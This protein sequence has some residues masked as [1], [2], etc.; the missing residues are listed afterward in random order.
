[1][2]NDDL[3]AYLQ[4]S[5]THMN[6]QEWRDVCRRITDIRADDHCL[7]LRAM[8]PKGM[9]R[10]RIETKPGAF[11]MQLAYVPM[12]QVP[13]GKQ[14]MVGPMDLDHFNQ[15]MALPMAR[16]YVNGRLKGGLWFAPPGPEQIAE[17][18]LWADLGFEVDE[19]G[20]TELRL[21][22]VEN[23]Q[24]SIRWA[25]MRSIEVR[26]DD[27][28]I[29]ELKP[30]SVQHPRVLVNVDDRDMLRQRLEKHPDYAKALSQA[31]FGS[32]SSESM[33]PT[34]VLY[35]VTG[36]AALGEQIRQ[37]AVELCQLPTWSG[38]PDPLLMGGDN[39]RLIGDRLYNLGMAWEYLQDLF[40]A[41]EKK[42]VLAKAEEY[43]QKMYDFTVLQRGY[44][45][46]PTTDAHSLGAWFGVATA[47]MC[48]YDDL[49]I[50]RKALAFFH[51]LYIESLRLFPPG[52][53]ANW[54]TFYP[55][56]LVR[57]L[58]AAH[59]FG[60]QRPELDKSEFLD[61]LGEALFTCYTTPNTQEMQS[62]A[63]TAPHRFLVAFL[64]RFHPTPGI[65]SIYRSFAEYEEK[66][67]GA[68]H[69]SLYDWLYAPDNITEAARP[70]PSHPL[71]IRDIGEV[72]CRTHGEKSVHASFIAGC[73]AGNRASFRLFPHNRDN[74]VPLGTFEV[75]VDGAPVVV[76]FGGYGRSITSQNTMCF[77]DG[78]LLVE[79]QYINGDI[80]AEIYASIR[81]C[82]ISDRFVYVHAVLTTGL[83]PKLNIRSAERIYLVDYQTGSIVVKDI[84]AGETPLRFA[85]HLHCSGSITQRPDGEY[86]LTGGQA[87]TIACGAATLSDDE[88]GEAF[89]SILQADRPHRVVV[90]EPAWVPAY[91]YNIN[92][93]GK[94]DFKDSRHPHYQRWRLEATELV[95]SGAFLFTVN[96]TP[97]SVSLVKENVVALPQDATYYLADNATV[98]ALGCSI[99]A[100]A[101]IVDEQAH[102]LAILGA[103]QVTGDNF[104]LTSAIPVDI[105]LDLSGTVARGAIFATG[106]TALTQTSGLQL[107]E[108]VFNESDMRS[109]SPWSAAFTVVAAVGVK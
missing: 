64:C 7:V 62:G 50:A 87:K 108:W 100:E 53:K 69:M 8:L 65:E 59:T 36:D 72:V 57:Y 42:L 46:C 68:V 92:F 91:V 99:V 12:I 74:D 27:R 79:G 26:T 32:R 30:A 107:A 88:R 6:P 86:R 2:L 52:G 25:D 49:P 10:A 29:Y 77:N 98:N 33:A 102:T 83:D 9:Y 51:G 31:V 58:A 41:D 44:M 11:D 96:P 17:N 66:T 84:F 109:A 22:F 81:R 23:H 37:T 70:F 93:T 24:E 38:R 67:L 3:I 106:Q 90:E 55:S 73:R 34:S 20:E 14:V 13:E 4:P 56:F 101:V 16:T 19:D 61:N 94:E 60:G 82:L 43:L 40:T 21:E 80:G 15:V 5:P 97:N 45:G 71:F 89:V 76:S 105:L 78:G 95:N 39:D 28:L 48:F 63:S 35:W 54:I 75:F 47:A 103:R 18:R 85:T 1:M 104:A